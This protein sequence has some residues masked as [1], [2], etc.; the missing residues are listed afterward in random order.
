MLPQKNQIPTKEVLFYKKKFSS[1]AKISVRYRL[2]DIKA[3]SKLNFKTFS[4]FGAVNLGP[5][6]HVPKTS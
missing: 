2:H 3:S 1:I 6:K 4:I 5:Q